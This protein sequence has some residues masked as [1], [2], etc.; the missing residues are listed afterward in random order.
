MPLNWGCG[1]PS[2]LE[3]IK[4]NCPVLPQRPTGQEWP[5]KSTRSPVHVKDF[6]VERQGSGGE[7]SMLLPS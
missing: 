1:Q 7:T 3:A 5:S 2:V 6:G 4:N